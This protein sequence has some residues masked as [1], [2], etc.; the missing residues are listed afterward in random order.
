ML[1]LAMTCGR[2]FTFP[3]T[4]KHERNKVHAESTD[5]PGRHDQRSP[6]PPPVLRTQIFRSYTEFLTN[7]KNPLWTGTA[8]K[9]WNKKSD[10]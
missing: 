4:P 10:L 7:R 2:C 6:T 1:R 5:Y 3:L 9:T 8:K